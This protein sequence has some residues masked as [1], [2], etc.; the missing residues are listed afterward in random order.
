MWE[1]ER[2]KR[3]QRFWREQSGGG[4]VCG[5]VSPVHGSQAGFEVSTTQATRDAQGLSVGCESGIQKR[6][7]E[8]GRNLGVISAAFKIM[9]LDEIS[10]EVHREREREEN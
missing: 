6:G 7:L 8:G 5:E 1:Q 10:K 3:T 4:Q 9:G 2:P